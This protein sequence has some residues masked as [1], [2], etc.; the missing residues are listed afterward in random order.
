M[1]KLRKYGSV[2]DS[3][4]GQS[5]EA[6]QS[7]SGMDES[8]PSDD[9]N[10]VDADN[11]DQSSE[12]M[13]KL[14]KHGNVPD[15]EI[16]FNSQSAGSSFAQVEKSQLTSTSGRPNLIDIEDNPPRRNGIEGSKESTHSVWNSYRER[17]KK[18]DKPSSSSS[19]NAYSGQ[20]PAT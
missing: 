12:P 13:T 14:R 4:E 10:M 17:K 6:G 8:Q 19:D 7:S 20:P 15:S 9:C 3:M 5:S 2:S 1:P 18:S 11:M 16:G